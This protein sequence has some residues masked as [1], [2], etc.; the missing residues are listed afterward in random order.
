[1]EELK[2]GDLVMLNSG[3]P[4]MAIIGMNSTHVVCQWGLADGTPGCSEFH[5]ATVT[6]VQ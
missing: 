6:K 3:G 4:L 5:I 1:M 2:L